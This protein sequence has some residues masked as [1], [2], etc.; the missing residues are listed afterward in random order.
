MLAA[1]LIGRLSFS[2]LPL[3]L[4]L[5]VQRATGSFAQAGLAVGAYA[6][7]SGLLA[8][9][10]G[11]R[12]DSSGAPAIVAFALAYS[13]SLGGIFAWAVFAGPGWLAI[14]LCSI[15][16]SV[17]PPLGP[18]TRTLLTRAMTSESLVRRAFVLDTLAEELI[19]VGGPLIAGLA[20]WL[21]H[22][23]TAICLAAALCLGGA[24]A[25]ATSQLAR[26]PA[27]PRGAEERHADSRGDKLDWSLLGLVVACLALLGAGLGAIEIGLPAFAVASKSQA[28][29]GALLAAVSAG[30]LLGGLWFGRREW[31]AGPGSQLAGAVLGFA[32]A[33]ALLPLANSLVVLGASAFLL[34]VFV[35]PSLVA[36]LMILSSTAPKTRQTE[37]FAWVTTANNAGLALGS[38]VAGLLASAFSPAAALSGGAVAGCLGLLPALALKRRLVSPGST[39]RRSGGPAARPVDA[40]Q[41]P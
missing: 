33:G 24:T 16:G 12:V 15:A 25:L 37:A 23:A 13:V 32:L 5:A 39:N 30:S 28:A 31:R 9:I 36:S 3:A 22:P 17:V 14:M 8:G 27:P 10:R 19:F 38:G 7:T 18:Y 35:A 4:I 20:I 2:V 21:G 34:G 29:A 11:R 26:T 40:P 1:S 41:R 6:L